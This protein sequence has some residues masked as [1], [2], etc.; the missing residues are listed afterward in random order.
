MSEIYR[1]LDANCNRARE[2]LRVLEDYC[3]FTLNHTQL[4]EKLK[5]IRHDLQSTTKQVQAQTIIHRDTENDVGT[6][7][8]TENEQKRESAGDVVIAAGKR[9]GEALRTIEEYL[10]TIDGASSKLIEKTRYQFYDLEKIIHLTLS[11]GRQRMKDVR[12]YVLITENLCKRHWLEVVEA[13]LKG[14][15]DCLQLREKDLTATELLVRAKKLVERCRHYHAVSI[16]NDRIDI[17]MLSGADGVHVG[18]A[19]LSAID[20]RKLVGMQKIVGVSTHAIAQAQQAVLDGAD[21][22]GVGPIFPSTTKPRDQL[23][24]IEYARN[25]AQ[26]INLPAV[27][28]SGINESNIQQIL[29]AGIKAVAVSSA[30]I[31]CEDPETACRRIKALLV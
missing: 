14:G 10:K 2:A 15:A 23:S 29:A 12:L 31:S 25:V 20:A 17:A 11:P 1:I 30:V 3:R 28:I 27:A 7:I 18:Q 6:T 21:Y 4:S 5:Q 8:T 19:D 16:I 24:G 13:A 22:I 26:N 9:L